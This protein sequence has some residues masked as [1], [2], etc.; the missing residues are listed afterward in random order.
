M[1]S[2]LTSIEK[3]LPHNIMETMKYYN[4]NTNPEGAT[5]SGKNMSGIGTT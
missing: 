3:F 1:K 5:T 2:K 4:Y